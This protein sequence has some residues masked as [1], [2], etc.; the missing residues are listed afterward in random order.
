MKFVAVSLALLSGCLM[1]CEQKPKVHYTLIE[2][3]EVAG[4]CKEDHANQSGK[5]AGF[6]ETNRNDTTGKIERFGYVSL[7]L[8]DQIH[9]ADNPG[10]YTP[11][12]SI[13]FFGN[14]GDLSGADLTLHGISSKLDDK[15]EDEFGAGYASTCD[16]TVTRRGNKPPSDA[17]LTRVLN[18]R[19]SG[20]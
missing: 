8:S 6:I 13:T 18:A 20:N 15:G 16:L 1:G 3:V 10:T 11:P 14:M 12:D 2:V 4:T 19:G 17:Q 9:I 5:Y 7:P